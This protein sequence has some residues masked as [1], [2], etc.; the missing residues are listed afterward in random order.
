M[1]TVPEI[2]YYMRKMQRILPTDEILDLQNNKAKLIEI[3]FDIPRFSSA[4]L[5]TYR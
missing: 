5:T 4:G 2:L 1:I 3:M